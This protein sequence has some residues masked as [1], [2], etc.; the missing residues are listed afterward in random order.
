MALDQGEW[1]ASVGSAIEMG[2]LMANWEERK[3]IGENGRIKGGSVVAGSAAVTSGGN[4]RSQGS[5]VEGWI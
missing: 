3:R 2:A 4:G 5:V 1:Q